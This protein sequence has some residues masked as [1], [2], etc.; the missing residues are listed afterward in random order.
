MNYQ[1]KDPH[2]NIN[3]KSINQTEEYKD[4]ETLKSMKSIVI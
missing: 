1:E 3:Q 4:D 2:F